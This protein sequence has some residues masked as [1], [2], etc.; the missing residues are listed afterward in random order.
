MCLTRKNKIEYVLHYL[1][2]LDSLSYT[3]EVFFACR[4]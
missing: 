2:K 1:R 4:L 3:A